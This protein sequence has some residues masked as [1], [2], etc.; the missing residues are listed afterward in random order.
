MLRRIGSVAL[1]A[2]LSGFELAACNRG[3]TSV[4][5]N[6]QSGEAAGEGGGAEAAL[7]TY[8][9]A[10]QGFSIGYPSPW[11]QDRTVTNGV[12]FA[13]ADDSLTLEFVVPPAG[14]DAMT[15]AQADTSKVS[16]SF[17]GFKLLSLTASTEVD[18]AVIL[19]FEATATSVVTGKSYTAHDER[20]YMP[21]PDGRL[22]ILTVTGP[23]NHYDREG[24]RDVAL[25]FRLTK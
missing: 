10:A 17:P 4:V 19:G 18:K 20:Y 3:G 21:L 13:G 25:T 11:T 2:L 14:T 5:G 23:G 9:D 6:G 8:A 7:V 22:A 12:R 15:F 24:V 1:I 16:S